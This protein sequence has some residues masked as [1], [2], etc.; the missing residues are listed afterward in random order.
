MTEHLLSENKGK[1]PLVILRPSIVGTSLKEPF[2][3]WTDSQ[4][5]VFEMYV[6]Y[7]L[8]VLREL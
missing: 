6:H 4:G 7:G 1:V 5:L 3:G 8:G 2:P